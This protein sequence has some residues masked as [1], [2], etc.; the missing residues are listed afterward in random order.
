MKMNSPHLS[1]TK[2]FEL[3]LT[4]K[5]QL[6]KDTNGLCLFAANALS[7]ALQKIG[8]MSSIQFGY[9]K[10]KR[11]WEKHSW[12][13]IGNVDGRPVLIDLTADQF[14]LETFRFDLFEHY[15]Q[16]YLYCVER[17]NPEDYADLPQ[18]WNQLSFLED[19]AW[20]K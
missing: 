9:V 20:D 14:D 10:S 3:A 6:P 8:I 11:G 12:L 7:E 13:E 4:I 16:E 5:R 19:W 17:T 1:L 2:E 18:D 15:R